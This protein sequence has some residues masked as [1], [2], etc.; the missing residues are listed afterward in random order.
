MKRNMFNIS[1]Y[2]TFLY[3]Q[4]FIS[5]QFTSTFILSQDNWQKKLPY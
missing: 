3:D 2:L 1:R 4:V 5:L